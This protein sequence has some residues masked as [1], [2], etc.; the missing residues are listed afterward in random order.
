MPDV[1]ER[2]T[3]PS[4]VRL[5]RAASHQSVAQAQIRPALSVPL[6]G[7]CA[8]TSSNPLLSPGLMPF[9][10]RGRRPCAVRDEGQG[11]EPVRRGARR[12][13]ALAVGHVRLN[14]ARQTR[15]AALPAAAFVKK[16]VKGGIQSMVFGGGSQRMVAAVRSLHWPPL[17]PAF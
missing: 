8:Y 5:R 4:V 9:P 1:F 14:L 15:S 7:L 12:H 11:G 16:R 2:L 3:R 17:F 6:P 10:A 13:P